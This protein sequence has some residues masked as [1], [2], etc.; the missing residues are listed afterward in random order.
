MAPAL[1][2]IRSQFFG[3]I[4]IF[5]MAGLSPG[6]EYELQVSLDGAFSQTDI[7]SKNFTTLPPDPSVSEVIVDKT[8]P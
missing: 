5:S 7:L 8:S 2:Q 4:S 1:T 6:T 3:G